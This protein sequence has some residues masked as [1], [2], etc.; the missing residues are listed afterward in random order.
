MSKIASNFKFISLACNILMQLVVYLTSVRWL[1]SQW[2]LLSEGGS[3]IKEC[4]ALSFGQ[5]VASQM[6]ASVSRSNLDVSIHYVVATMS[7]T[8]VIPIVGT[9]TQA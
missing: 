9:S 3:E 6:P 7:L 2:I 1:K 4:A 8:H 5:S